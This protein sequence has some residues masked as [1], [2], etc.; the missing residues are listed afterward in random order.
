MGPMA[1][2]CLLFWGSCLGWLL[3]V[4]LNRNCVRKAEAQLP[5]GYSDDAWG[6]Q[7]MRKCK[8]LVYAGA[9]LSVINCVACIAIIVVLVMG[10]GRGRN[11]Y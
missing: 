10:M 3:V 5:P 11:R 7:I 9:P 8:A 1:F 2:W 4:L 6:Q